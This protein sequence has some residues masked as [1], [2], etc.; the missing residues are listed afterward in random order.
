MWKRAN[1]KSASKAAPAASSAAAASLAAVLTASTAS[2]ARGIK[3]ADETL[4]SF[5]ESIDQCRLCVR[6]AMAVV[7]AFSSAKTE[8]NPAATRSCNLYTAVFDDGGGLAQV[9]VECKMLQTICLTQKSQSEDV[10]EVFHHLVQGTLSND[11]R[12]AFRLPSS[13]WRRRATMPGKSAGPGST[14]KSGG[15][16]ASKESRSKMMSSN[17]V[18]VCVCVYGCACV[19]ACVR[20]C[21]C[22]CLRVRGYVCVVCVVCVSGGGLAGKL[23]RRADR[24][25]H[26]R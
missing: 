9:S 17:G 11:E 1:H 8:A 14:G 22:V 18:C 5:E 4:T 13:G 20:V 6:E 21:A 12:A 25:R 15:G 24:R 16:A 7:A 26:W 23:V 10:F 3:F 2:T 19:R